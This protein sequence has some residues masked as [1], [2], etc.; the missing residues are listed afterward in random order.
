MGKTA[1]EQWI[2][3]LEEK[4]EKQIFFN[5]G[6]VLGANIVYDDLLDFMRKRV[7]ENQNERQKRTNQDKGDNRS[8]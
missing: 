4:K 1:E 8:V 7:K 6:V 2:E 5:M 3:F